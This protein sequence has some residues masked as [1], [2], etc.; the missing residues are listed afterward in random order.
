M[1]RIAGFLLGMVLVLAAFLLVLKPADTRPPG[2]RVTTEPMAPMQAHVKS[3][4]PPK[5]VMD[6][7]PVDSVVPAGSDID[8]VRTA[9]PR[10][11]ILDT[12]AL[13]HEHNGA[14]QNR[15]LFWSPFRSE[16]AAQGF[17]N[18][19]AVATRVPVE[20]IEEGAGQYR[21]GF[22]YRNE[23]ERRERIEQIESITGLHLE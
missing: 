17:A 12:D 16:W 4:D 23:L 8:T 10:D 2:I 18:R 15:Y 21:V 5:N 20:V 7:L 11:G 22:P 13:L 1:V 3:S 6:T 9:A 19:L 14:E